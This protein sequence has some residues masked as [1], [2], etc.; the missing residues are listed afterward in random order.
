MKI[1]KAR[2]EKNEVS[3]RKY[4]FAEGSMSGSVVSIVGEPVSSATRI[5]EIR[6]DHEEALKTF[7]VESYLLEEMS[8][9]E[10]TRFEQHCFEC[11]S[12]TEAVE[13]VRIFVSNIVPPEQTVTA[14]PWYAR[15]FQF[16]NELWLK[17]AAVMAAVL[18]P[19]TGWQQFVIADLTGL[20]ANTVILARGLEKGAAERAAPLRTPSATVEVTLPSDA[21]FAFYRVSIL[22][23]QNRSF[24]QIVPAPAKDSTRRLSVQVL[25]KTLGSGRFTVL[26]E[27][28]DAEDSRN[29]QKLDE[30]YEF[31]LK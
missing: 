30:S 17:S 25:R 13:A 10:E 8:E 26:V 5:L 29:G 4:N 7:A 11:A 19:I 20:H 1:R 18:L 31:D 3:K 9:E 21:E 22:G 27:G 23:G 6:K 14:A 2:F 28:L 15:F 24:S 12:C 16:S